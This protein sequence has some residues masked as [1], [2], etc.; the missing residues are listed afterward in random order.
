MPREEIPAMRE[1]WF[2]L[3]ATVT[4]SLLSLGTAFVSFYWLE[5][6]AAIKGTGIEAGGAIAGYLLVFWALRRLLHRLEAPVLNSLQTLSLVHLYQQ[7]TKNEIIRASFAWIDD[8]EAGNPLPPRE[9]RLL[10][11]NG[12]RHRMREIMT[13]FVTPLGDINK[14]LQSVWDKEADRDL[15]RGM[16]IVE[17]DLPAPVKRKRLWDLA[18]GIEQEHRAK[19]ISMLKNKGWR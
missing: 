11:I 9:E 7:N 10:V 13:G 16:E 12:I 3:L 8:V 14:E 19:V 2:S 17:S 5:S 18:D 15:A 6:F 4:I 1:K